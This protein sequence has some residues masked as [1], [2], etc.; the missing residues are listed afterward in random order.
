MR[1]AFNGDA[2]EQELVKLL[3]PVMGIDHIIETGTFLGHTTT[4]LARSFPSLPIETVEIDEKFVARARRNLGA[5]HNV[6]IHHA[7]SAVLL[8]DRAG[9]YAAGNPLFYLDAHWDPELP[10][11]SELAAIMALARAALI[12]DDFKVP[13]RPDYAFAVAGGVDSSFSARY[14]GM[15]PMTL[16]GALDNDSIVGE[17]RGRRHVQLFPRYAYREMV[18]TGARPKF[19]NLVGYTVLL[20]GQE[21][22]RLERFLREPFVER[23]FTILERGDLDPRSPT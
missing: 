23:Y 14:R 4:F 6:T 10:L 15:D 17:V 12:I 1:S 19:Q 21:Q 11:A 5:C 2:I 22:A 16:P 20:H 9:S 7:D 18:R 3:V 13:G 8:S